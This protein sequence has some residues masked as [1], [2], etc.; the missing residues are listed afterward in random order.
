M[1]NFTFKSG[2]LSQTAF[3]NKCILLPFHFQEDFQIQCMKNMK[4]H[5][6]NFHCKDGAQNYFQFWNKHVIHEHCFVKHSCK[7]GRGLNKRV[8]KM[9]KI[10]VIGGLLKQICLPLMTQPFWWGTGIVGDLCLSLVTLVTSNPG[11]NGWQPLEPGF[12]VH[13]HWLWTTFKTE[14]RSHL[15]SLFLHPLFN[16]TSPR[17]GTTSDRWG[18]LTKRASVHPS[19]FQSPHWPR[20]TAR[21]CDNWMPGW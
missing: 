4:E 16:P 10:I 13:S 8:S 19:V 14:H 18:G 20:L 7:R 5:K 11:C 2:K 21:F 15:P 17:P 6:I 1:F 12:V 3:L 9:G